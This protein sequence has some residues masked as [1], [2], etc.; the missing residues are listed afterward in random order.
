MKKSGQEVN[1]FGM[2]MPGMEMLQPQAIAECCS[3][4][5]AQME[6]LSRTMMGSMQ[7]T[8]DSAWDLSAQVARNPGDATRLCREWMDERR[9]AFFVEGKQISDMWFRLCDM[10]P[11]PGAG[12][13]SAVSPMSRAGS[14]AE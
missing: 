9:D 2:P 11:V 13:A 10:R 8:V 7:R 1:M 14:A 12:S 3:K 4:V 5:S 6:D